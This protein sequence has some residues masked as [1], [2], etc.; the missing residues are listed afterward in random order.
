MTFPE[1]YS[2]LLFVSYDT[3]HAR[4][5]QRWSTSLPR[6]GSRVRFPSRALRKKED[7]QNACLLF[8]EAH[9]C[10]EVRFS[11]LRSGPRIPT[12]P[13]RRAPSRAY[14]RDNPEKSDLAGAIC[15]FLRA[16]Q[17]CT[18]L[19][20]GSLLTGRHV[21]VQTYSATARQSEKSHSLATSP[22]RSFKPPL[23]SGPR[24]ADVPRTSCAVSRLS[25]RRSRE[26]RPRGWAP[27]SYWE[28]AL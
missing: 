17:G 1:K 4:V 5:A 11:P 6:R 27:R 21:R 9:P 18:E 7:M 12:S 23:R 22:T 19:A 8:F 2:I 24:N 10:L 28:L 25:A 16:V 26:E 13:G 15:A 14:L 3:T 20:A